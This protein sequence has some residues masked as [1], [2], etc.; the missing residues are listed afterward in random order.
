MWRSIPFCFHQWIFKG[1]VCCV[2]FIVSSSGLQAISAACK[3]M[4]KWCSHKHTKQAS[5][6]FSGQKRMPPQSPQHRFKNPPT[7]S[8]WDNTN[9]RKPS[10]YSKFRPKREFKVS[11]KLRC[12]G[13]YRFKICG[14]ILTDNF[15]SSFFWLVPSE[16]LVSTW[17]CCE[18]TSACRNSN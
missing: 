16:P 17:G 13:T 12:N 4:L 5:T 14:M 6:T 11:S 2:D 9:E 7:H 15:P 3:R 10:V 18:T 1:G 8:P